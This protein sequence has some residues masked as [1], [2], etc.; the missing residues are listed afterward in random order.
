MKKTLLISFV[1]LLLL[2]VGYSVGIGYYA[3]KFQANTKF[4]A[5]DISNLTLDEALK[6]IKADLSTAKI[7][8]TENGKELGTLTLEELKGKVNA[9]E[10]LTAAYQSQD[11]TLWIK[12][13][14]ASKE[15][16]NLLL[17]KV[18]IADEDLTAGLQKLGINNAERKAAKDASIQYSDA[19][20]YYVEEAESGNQLDL[21]KVKAMIVKGIQNGEASIEINTAY[22]EPKLKANDEKITST[23]EKIEKFA[24]TKITLQISGDEVTV[25]KEEILKWIH[26]DGKNNIVADKEAAQA[27]VKTLNEKYATYNKTRQFS[28]TLQGTVTVQPG[29]LGWSIDSESEAAQLAKDLEAGKDVK[30]EPAIVGTGYGKEGDD[31]GGTYVEVD[32]Q[33]QMMYVYKDYEQVLSTAIVTGMAGSSETIPGAYAI[34]NKE[35]NATL[36]GTRVQTGTDYRQ[37]VAYWMPF[38]TT[39]QGIHDASWQS[40]FGGDAYLYAGSQGCINTPPEVMAVL[41]SIVEVGT[42]VIIF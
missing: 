29:T 18:K 17:N 33:N 12:G 41:F 6:K 16:D 40:N 9:K 24:S 26:F 37:P 8:V 5:I 19:R 28:S 32:M 38:D 15:Y 2:G 7:K 21:E 42:P 30:R 36:V 11:P 22:L 35:R 31:I 13:F 10:V 20:G 39:G 4:G 1:T 23:M 34:W 25:P 27:Y 3:E 14:F